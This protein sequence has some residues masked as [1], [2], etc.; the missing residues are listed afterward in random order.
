MDF[1]G[2]NDISLGSFLERYCFRSSYACPS[3]SCETSMVRHVRRF[4]H[5][6]GCVHIVLKELDKPIPDTEGNNIV[7]WSW[8]SRCKMVSC[9]GQYCYEASLRI[10]TCYDR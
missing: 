3:E 4:V 7:M 2:H 1:Y 6:M 8:C 9:V 5:D 10:L